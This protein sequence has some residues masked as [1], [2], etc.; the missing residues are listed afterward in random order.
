M[1]ILIGTD[2]AGYGPNLGPLVISASVWHLPDS[3]RDQELYEL[4]QGSVARAGRHSDQ[5]TICDSK[6]LYHPGGGLAELE[7]SLLSCLAALGRFP[8]TCVELWQT[9]ASDGD[10]QRR[11]VPWYAAYCE[12]LPVAAVDVEC[13]QLGDRL[14]STAAG[15]DTELLDLCSTI[16]TEP[17]Y[18][19]RL[20][21]CGNKSTLLSEAT[22]Q[23]IATL[24]E[25]CPGE[26][27]RGDDILVQCDKHGGRNRYG[28]LLQHTFPDVWIETCEES[29]NVSRY[30]WVDRGRRVEVRFQCRGEVFL[31]AA[32]ASICSKYFREMAM[33]AFNHYWQQQAPGVRPTAGYPQDARRFYRDIEPH[34][35]RLKVSDDSLWRRK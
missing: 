13:R 5:V 22:L 30:C 24:M 16:V 32:L 20:E 26:D 23:L 21:F 19:R 18:N 29:R 28:A 3:C 11:A 17:E 10:S 27:G 12:A 7:R 2:E 25:E 4:L 6:Q 9:L 33:R 15:V 34:R 31:P 1:A 8:S 14:R 35:L